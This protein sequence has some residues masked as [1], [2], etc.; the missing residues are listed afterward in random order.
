MMVEGG[1]C[2]GCKFYRVEDFGIQGVILAPG[3]CMGRAGG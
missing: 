2:G 1:G 3:G